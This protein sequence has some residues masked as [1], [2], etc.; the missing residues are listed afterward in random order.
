[1]KRSETIGELAK[2]LSAAQGEYPPIKKTATAIVNTDKAKYSYSY[3]ELECVLAAARSINHKHGLALCQEVSVEEQCVITTSLLLHSSGEWIEGT[4]S[5]PITQGRMN[6]AQAIG[7]AAT[8]GRRYGASAILGLASEDDDDGKN[9]GDAGEKLR[10]TNKK[11]PKPIAL[12]NTTKES[13]IPE[14]PDPENR[15]P[16]EDD[17]RPVKCQKIY[18]LCRDGI[19]AILA[20]KV[21]NPAQ[22]SGKLKALNMLVKNLDALRKMYTDVKADYNLGLA[23]LAD[24]AHQ[25]ADGNMDAPDE[26]PT[27]EP[28]LDPEPEKTDP[29]EQEM[30]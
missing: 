5:I 24:H 17:S 2:A 16:L 25:P 7:S 15:I 3:A 11:S 27:P 21:I 28:G 14:K 20:E 1:M 6:I 22:Y 10:S 12:K 8:Y 4:L 18:W 26:A 30:F 23:A 13:E 29:N 19:D 9:S